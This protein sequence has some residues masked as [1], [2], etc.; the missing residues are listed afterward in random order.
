MIVTV[1]NGKSSLE[2]QRTTDD[3]IDEAIVPSSFEKK[4]IL[5]GIGKIQ[6]IDKAS[7]QV[8]LKK[9]SSGKK[10]SALKA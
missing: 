9:D 1:T 6:V 10:C 8:G 5:Q 7:L 2:A 3:G 4:A